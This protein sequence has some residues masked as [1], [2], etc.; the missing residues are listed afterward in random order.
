MF[1][2]I[3][4][5]FDCLLNSNLEEIDI[6]DLITPVTGVTLNNLEAKRYGKDVYI[7][8]YAEW[9]TSAKSTRLFSIDESLIPI[10][11]VLSSCFFETGSGYY[12]GYVSIADLLASAVMGTSTRAVRINLH[13]RIS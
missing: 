11:P 3:L 12:F 9:T 4:N 7:T 2:F 10:T 8:T 1:Y 6:S 13:W 5:I